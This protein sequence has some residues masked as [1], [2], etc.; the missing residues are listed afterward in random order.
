MDAHAEAIRLFCDEVLRILSGRSRISTVN[1]TEIL[2]VLLRAPQP[3]RWLGCCGCSPRFLL[4]DA[5]G[6]FFWAGGYIAAGYAFSSQL[7]RV[8]RL[9]AGPGVSLTLWFALALTVFLAWKYVQR[10]ALL[11]RSPQS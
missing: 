9:A 10:R 2:Q 8:A 11:H 6:A 3:F 1:M 7:E 5:A 4:F